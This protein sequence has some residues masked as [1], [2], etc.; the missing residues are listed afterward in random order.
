MEG[1]I[2]LFITI[3]LDSMKIVIIGQNEGGSIEKM[4]HSLLPYRYERIW[5]LDRCTDDSSSILSE[6]G[7]YFVKTP[8]WL[9]GRQTAYARNLGATIAQDDVLFLDGD[10]YVV[11]G[12]IEGIENTENDIELLTI[13]KDSRIGILNYKQIYGRVYNG[14]FSCGLFIKRSAIEKV[15]RFQ[16]ELFRIDMQADW[17]IEDTGLGDVCYHLRLSAD[18]F[19][20][21][22]LAGSF[23]KKS[24]DRSEILVKRFQ[25]RDKLN[26]KW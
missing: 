5:V 16:G 14:F 24:L 21:C 15:V 26:V 3:Q 13:E 20:R 22:V 9:E 25:F 19:R 23:D 4:L 11:A 7:E 8:D 18:L 17:G 10:R 12:S 2:L 1:G 6:H